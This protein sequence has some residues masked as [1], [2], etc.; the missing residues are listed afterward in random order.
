MDMEIIPLQN[1]RL[2]LGL[3]PFRHCPVSLSQGWPFLQ[4]PHVALQFTP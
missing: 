4:F 2:K 3:H 1:G